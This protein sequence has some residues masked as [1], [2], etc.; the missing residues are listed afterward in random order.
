[1]ARNL[2]D[3]LDETGDTVGMLRNSQLGT[4]IYPVVPA[5]FTNWRS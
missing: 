5:E 4:Y 2:Q 3:L 1:M